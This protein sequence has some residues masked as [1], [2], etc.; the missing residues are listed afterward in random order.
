M[1]IDQKTLHYLQQLKLK[2]PEAFRGGHLFYGCLKTKGIMDELKELLPWLLAGAV[3]I[4]I[5]ILFSQYLDRQGYAHASQLASLLIILCFMCYAPL[6]IKQAK[7]S[8]NSFYQQHRST[9]LKLA[10]LIIVQA[11]NLAYLDSAFV[12]G[13]ILL[14][15]I[16]FGCI[17]FYKEN[18]FRAETTLQHYAHLHMIR[19]ACFWSYKRTIQ[20]KWRYRL[21][22]KHSAKR[23]QHARQV[24]YYLNLHLEL[25]KYEHELCKRYKYL[26]LEKYLDSLM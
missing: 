8:S 14:F 18:L 16:N 25:Y 15:A 4:P 3:F 11:C 19:C 6:I 9:P 21:M 22:S 5:Q 20:A 13:L 17:R 26:D 12:Q 7:H 1:S 2:H 23:H 10:C 24:Q